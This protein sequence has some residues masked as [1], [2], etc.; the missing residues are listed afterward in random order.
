MSAQNTSKTS[1]PPSRIYNPQNKPQFQLS[2][3]TQ[4]K[5]DNLNFEMKN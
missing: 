4:N 1:Y 3:S 5:I 2:I